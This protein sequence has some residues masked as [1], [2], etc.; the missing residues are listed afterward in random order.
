MGA[1]KKSAGPV[2]RLIGVISDASGLTA[3]RVVK[4][5]MV[6]FDHIPYEL[7][8]MPNV[9]TIEQVHDAV[10]MVKKQK[11]F[12]AFTLVSPVLRNET[13]ARA[14]EAGVETVDL[15]GPLLDTLSTFLSAAPAR[16]AGRFGKQDAEYYDRLEAISFTVRHDDGLALHEVHLADLVITGP[17]RTAKTPLSAYLAHTRGLKVANVPLFPELEPPEMLKELDPRRVVGLTMNARVLSAIRRQRAKELGATV[18]YAQI[19]YV[20][21]DLKHCHLYYQQAP[22]WTVVDMTHKS[23]E[24]VA[25]AICSKTI[26]TI[27]I[28]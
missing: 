22:E 13:I 7:K 4:A 26:D 6:Q 8:L 21:R 20:R 15:I 9:Q 11:G 14:N 3:E 23:I 24:E 12:L 18:E 28:P 5:T 27:A 19:Q 25:T 1:Q 17:S 10:A 16:E 2:K